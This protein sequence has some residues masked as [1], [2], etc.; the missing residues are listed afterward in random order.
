VE[1]T[2]DIS[3]RLDSESNQVARGA[4]FRALSDIV[5]FVISLN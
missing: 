2:D 1:F 3:R 4:S 5:L